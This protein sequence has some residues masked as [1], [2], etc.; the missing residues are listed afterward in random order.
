[1]LAST[2]KTPTAGVLTSV[3]L[4]YTRR[5]EYKMPTAYVRQPRTNLSNSDSPSCL[6]GTY[7]VGSTDSVAA[8]LTLSFQG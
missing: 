2:P 3:R 5:P 7:S 4:L 1:M 8:L 6:N